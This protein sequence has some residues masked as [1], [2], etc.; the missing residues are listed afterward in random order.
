MW[1]NKEKDIFR[2]HLM[3]MKNV[4]LNWMSPFKTSIQRKSYK[5]FWNEGCFSAFPSLLVNFRR[6]RLQNKTFHSLSRSKAPP[7]ATPAAPPAATPAAPPAATPAA[8][9]ATFKVERFLAC[10]SV[11]ELMSWISQ[12]TLN[13]NMRTLTV[14]FVFIVSLT[15]NML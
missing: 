15:W 3:K 10:Y 2:L 5:S 8:T 13:I 1:Y 4:F 9:P 7:A 12:H 11:H 6:C 14:P